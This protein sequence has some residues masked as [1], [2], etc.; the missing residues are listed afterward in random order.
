MIQREFTLLAGRVYVGRVIEQAAKKVRKRMRVLAG[1]VACAVMLVSKH[2]RP[3]KDKACPKS[4]E[5]QEAGEAR[6]EQ[7][8]S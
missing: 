5:G 6:H 7:S 3:L 1:K 2:C 8:A 4:L